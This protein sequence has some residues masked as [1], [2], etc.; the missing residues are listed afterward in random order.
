MLVVC[1]WNG[2]VVWQR[3]RC[4]SQGPL[5]KAYPQRHVKEAKRRDGTPMTA[6]STPGYFTGRPLVSRWPRPTGERLTIRRH[7]SVAFVLMPRSRPPL[8]PH[9]QAYPHQSNRK[10]QNGVV[11]V[12]GQQGHEGHDHNALE[13]ISGGPEGKARG[14]QLTVLA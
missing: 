8:G 7:G 4:S 9:D 12:V 10:T 14:P 5:T 11:G 13:S 1:L 6:R 3:Q 2:G